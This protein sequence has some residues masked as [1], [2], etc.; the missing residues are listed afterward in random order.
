M[1]GLLTL[2]RWLVHTVSR[3][4]GAGGYLPGFASTRLALSILE[5]MAGPSGSQA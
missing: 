3:S 1:R 2:L 5:P 4:R